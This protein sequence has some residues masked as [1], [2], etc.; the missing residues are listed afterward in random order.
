MILL[1]VGEETVANE[2]QPARQSELALEE[3]ILRWLRHAT[4]MTTIVNEKLLKAEPKYMR[5]QH[6]NKTT[7]MN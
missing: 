1:A 5:A 6:D 7:F 2:I 3:K 4:L